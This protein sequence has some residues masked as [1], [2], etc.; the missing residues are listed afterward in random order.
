MLDTSIKYGIESTTEK[1]TVDTSISFKYLSL[2]HGVLAL[3]LCAPSALAGGLKL[4]P[5]AQKALD[6][7]YGGDPDAAIAAARD[8]ERAQPESPVGYLLEGEAK[9]W[10][11]YC[12]A[13][14]I[15]WGQFDAWHRAKVPED[16]AYLALADKAI[17]LARAQIAK[18]D[19]ADMHVYA[20]L[21]Y[22]LKAR[23]FSLRDEKRA[24]A[25]AGVAGRSEFLRALQLDPDMADATAGVGLYNY[26]IDTLSAIAR[27]LR[28]FMGLP[29]GNKQEGIR[30]MRV[31]IERGAW[32][33]VDSSFY[34][35]RNLRTYDERY[36]DALAVAEPLASRYPHNPVFLLLAGN[37]EV[38][39]GRNAK[40]VEHFRAAQSAPAADSACASRAR[41]VAGEFLASV[42]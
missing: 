27:M 13:C 41:S 14:E 5:E 28:V 39:L 22:A 3:A 6:Q 29:G 34:L 33:S 36:A 4:A 11:F 2:I 26:Y 17:D 7:I 12:A 18:S 9:W 31:G 30:Q 24:I 25:H 37:L 16:E 42:H 20:G 19:T 1:L 21:G 8:I 15:K 35:A 32:M 40:A 38:E 23:L 10:K